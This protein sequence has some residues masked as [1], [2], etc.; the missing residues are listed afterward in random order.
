MICANCQKNFNERADH[1]RCCDADVCCLSCA[2]SRIEYISSFDPELNA[3]FYWTDVESN[4]T[5]KKCKKHT[6]R[7]L[8]SLSLSTIVEDE[9]EYKPRL[10]HKFV[11]LTALLTLLYINN[12]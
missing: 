11:M 7:C 3:P 6:S 10:S 9:H 2:W 1:L 5:M 12:F 8:S 4:A